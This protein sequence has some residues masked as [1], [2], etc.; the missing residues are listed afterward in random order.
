MFHAAPYPP[1]AIL[2]HTWGNAK[3]E[4]SFEDL[5]SSPQEA[6]EKPRLCQN[7]VLLQDCP[8]NQLQI[9]LGGHVLVRPGCPASRI[10]LAASW[11]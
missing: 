10:L 9:R 5:Q 4:V 1:Y 6:R 3:D 2:S 11:P 8:R 7:R